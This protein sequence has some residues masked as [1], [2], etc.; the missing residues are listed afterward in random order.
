MID[1]VVVRASVAQGAFALRAMP[2]LRLRIL[3]WVRFGWKSATRMRADRQAE[4]SAQ[5]GR[6]R[7]F[8]LRRNPCRDRVSFSS[9][10]SSPDSAVNSFRS[11]RSGRYGQ[12]WGAVT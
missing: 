12:V 1:G 11:T 5:D 10:A 2:A 7:T 8:W 9:C 6:Y 4:H 3:R